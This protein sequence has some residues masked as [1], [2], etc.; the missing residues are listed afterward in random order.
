MCVVGGW[1]LEQRALD[2]AQFLKEHRA[3]K[4][5]VWLVWG[6]CVCVCVCV[7]VCYRF[8][9]RL[10]ADVR[11]CCGQRFT[12]FS[13]DNGFPLRFESG[14]PL[15]SFVF[16]QFGSAEFGPDVGSGGPPATRDGRC[17]LGPPAIRV[18]SEKASL[19]SRI[20][21][22]DHVGPRSREM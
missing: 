19:A 20:I 16:G 2:E 9:Q 14:L 1:C 6:W 11:Y 18:A 4:V 10:A 17:R 7:C 5:G 13:S 12:A 21:S 3:M 8:R 22:A 15:L